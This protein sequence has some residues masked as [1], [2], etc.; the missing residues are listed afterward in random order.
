MQKNNLQ[1]YIKVCLLFVGVLLFR[2]IPFRAPNVE[3]ILGTLMPIGKKT[4]NLIL[5]FYFAFLSI[6]FYDLLTSGLGVWT[7]ITAVAYGMVGILGVLY[8]KKRAPSR[9]NFVSF[10]VFGTILY[11]VLTGLTL[12]PI[13]FNQPFMSALFGQIPFTLLHLLGS[14][15]FA[16]F[17]SPLV[18][19]LLQK[20]F[21]FSFARQKTFKV[22]K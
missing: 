4:G 1:N 16:F 12:G 3:P 18:Y 2:L 15:T 14:V 10:A 11:D 7:I 6:V 17:V 21:S 22:V 20:K 9:K 5:P 19:R 8:F 13:F